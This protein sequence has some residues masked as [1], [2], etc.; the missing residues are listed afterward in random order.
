ME[1]EKT[2]MRGLL[3]NEHTSSSIV[4]R[5]KVDSTSYCNN[6]SWSFEGYTHMQTFVVVILE[7][8]SYLPYY[9]NER[10]HMGI[11]YQTPLEVLQRCWG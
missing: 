10:L 4:R 9:N 3:I 5:E 2:M 7:I 11:N 6:L 8:I 1:A